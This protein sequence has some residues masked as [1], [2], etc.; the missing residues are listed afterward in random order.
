MGHKGFF[1]D[2]VSLNLDITST[3]PTSRLATLLGFKSP[4]HPNSLDFRDFDWNLMDLNS[5]WA[6]GPTLLLH[7]VGFSQ[8]VYAYRSRL[9]VTGTMNSTT[10]NSDLVQQYRHLEHRLPSPHHAQACALD[11]LH[12]FYYGTSTSHL[13]AS[14]LHEDH[15]SEP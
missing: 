10:V 6:L 5:D 4:H 9:M 14:R 13:R 7:D 8:L 11:P 12:K 1:L 3:L 2:C 15:T